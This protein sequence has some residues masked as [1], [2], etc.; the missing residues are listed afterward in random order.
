MKAFFT[1]V[2]SLIGLSAFSQN[3]LITE[4]GAADLLWNMPELSLTQN[5]MRVTRISS[6][7]IETPSE[8]RYKEEYFQR[9]TTPTRESEMKPLLYS[10]AFLEENWK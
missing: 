10:T 2:I 8:V 3:I 1:L 5:S 4:L 6:N 7:E 9:R